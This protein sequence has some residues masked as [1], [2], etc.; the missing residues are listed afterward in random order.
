MFS[1][2][3]TEIEDNLGVTV[4]IQC[5]SG[6]VWIATSFINQF[7]AGRNK[8]IPIKFMALWKHMAS[9][10]DIGYQYDPKSRR[11]CI[12]FVDKL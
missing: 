8:L 10:K 4:S 5:K 6:N 9:P 7:S 1:D 3:I 12:I 11:M 2:L